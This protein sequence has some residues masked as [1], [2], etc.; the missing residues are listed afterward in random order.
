MIFLAPQIHL[1]K[2]ILSKIKKVA[3]YDN[4]QGGDSKKC[5]YQLQLHG[6]F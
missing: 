2:V 4:T 6:S 5:S 3:D 1:L